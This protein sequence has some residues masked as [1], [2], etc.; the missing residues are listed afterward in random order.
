MVYPSILKRRSIT[1]S[2]ILG[3]ALFAALIPLMFRSIYVDEAMFLANLPLVRVSDAF[4]PL[5]HYDQ[6]SPPFF[7]LLA[8]AL[9][10]LPPF[11]FRCALVAI[12][13]PPILLSLRLG[14][15]KPWQYALVFAALFSQLYFWR[16][17]SEIKHYGFEQVGF[18]I[19]ISWFIAKDRMEQLRAADLGVLIVVELL[20]FSTIIIA[21]ICLFLFI[22]ESVLARRKLP[23]VATIAI[24]VVFLVGTGVY[25]VLTRHMTIIQMANYSQAYGK[26]SAEGAIMMIRAA[27]S[28]ISALVVPALLVSIW[29]L[30]NAAA[31]QNGR[32]LRLFFVTATAFC[33]L[34][35]FHIYPGYQKRQVLWV[36]TF[37]IFSLALAIVALG[38]SLGNAPHPLFAPPFAMRFFKW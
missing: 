1:G 7:T 32:F 15:S 10:A 18:F 25:Y 21:V 20:G 24:S 6:A 14:I 28:N 17:M 13:L 9:I 3:T 26:G 31:R 33:V 29:I 34:T 23:G 27:L 12:S 38:Q 22:F 4:A 30:A 19:A 16:E 37:A 35:V 11:A 5:L 36:S 2:V 8:N